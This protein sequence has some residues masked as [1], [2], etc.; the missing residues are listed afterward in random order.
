MLFVAR[1]RSDWVYAP[2]PSVFLLWW[3]SWVPRRIR[4]RVVS[5]AYVSLW[6][7]AFRD[8][9]AASEG[10]LVS[11]LVRR[12]ESRSLRAAEL[13]LVDTCANKAWFISDFGVEPERI[14]VVPL[15][16]RI[17]E[18]TTDQQAGRSDPPSP[19]SV[20]FVG[21]LV[22][23]H[24]I[25]IVAD[26][27]RR[28]AKSRA[29]VTFHFIGDGQDRELLEAL[30]A[31]M[32][33]NVVTWD[34]TWKSTDEIY[35]S[36]RS[37]HVCLGVFGGGGKAS[38]VLPFK[39]YMALAAGRAVVTQADWSLPDGVPPPPVIKVAADGASLAEA[40]DGLSRDRSG[41]RSLS[42]QAEGYFQ[43]HLGV[44]SIATAWR[45]ILDPGRPGGSGS[46]QS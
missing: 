30:C 39:V 23:L 26:A 24:G 44:A 33:G 1:H 32:G 21:T 19:L 9:N 12:F 18:P 7:A 27:V 40:L 46:S 36:M 10:S 17:P 42:E 41:L 31:E 35:D 14:R 15:A 38:R 22:P 5:D 2:Y 28:L 4:P 11:R 29:N 16:I 43:R 13:V 8:R 3:L 45:S 25:R 20:L 6:D 34:R 37:A